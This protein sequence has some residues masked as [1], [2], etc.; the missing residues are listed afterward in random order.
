MIIN[1][2]IFIYLIEIAIEFLLLVCIENL[3]ERGK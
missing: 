3:N 2:L 1:N